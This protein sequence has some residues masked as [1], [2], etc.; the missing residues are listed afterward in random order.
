MAIYKGNMFYLILRKN[1][2]SIYFREG[3]K[4]KKWLSSLLGGGG[5]AR[6]IYPFSAAKA[7]LGVQMSVGGSVGLSVMFSFDSL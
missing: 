2:P 4:K 7:A 6:V 1:M 5:S 3:F